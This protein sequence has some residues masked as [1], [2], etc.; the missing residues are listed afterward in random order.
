LRA[1]G[2]TESEKY[3]LIYK[4]DEAKKAVILY[5]ISLRRHVYE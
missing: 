5:D 1:F 2:K 4:I 3:R